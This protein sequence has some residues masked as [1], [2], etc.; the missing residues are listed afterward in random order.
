MGNKESKQFMELF[1]EQ[2]E[3]VNR[4]KYNQILH[5]A[6]NNNWLLIHKIDGTEELCPS[7]IYLT[8]AGLTVQISFDE[9]ELRIDNVP[10]VQGLHLLQI[11]N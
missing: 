7:S 2:N 4:E 9:T 1:Y 5:Y 8:P 11:N 3:K 6:N 10:S